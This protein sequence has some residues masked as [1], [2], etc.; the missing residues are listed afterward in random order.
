MSHNLSLLIVKVLIPA[1]CSDYKASVQDQINQ[2]LSIAPILPG[3]KASDFYNFGNNTQ[4]SAPSSSKTAEP[5]STQSA[6]PPQ[7]MSAAQADLI[8]FGQH[9]GSKVKPPSQSSSSRADDA[10]PVGL[11]Q[12]LQPSSTQNHTFRQDS[13]AGSVDEFV[14]AES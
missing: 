2:I 8:D 13:I 12:P 14:D 5:L 7:P 11:Q 3:Q 10:R 4:T 1:L 9:D 6:T